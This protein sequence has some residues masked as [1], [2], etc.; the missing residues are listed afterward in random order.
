MRTLESQ[1]TVCLVYLGADVGGGQVMFI[2]FVR[3]R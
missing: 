3:C 2:V 1:G